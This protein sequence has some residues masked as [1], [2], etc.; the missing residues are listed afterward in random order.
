MP[1]CSTVHTGTE[2]AERPHASC[3]QGSR[4]GVP[5]AE[6]WRCRAGHGV[7]KERLLCPKNVRMLQTP[8]PATPEAMQSNVFLPH[9]PAHP[10]PPNP[11]HMQRCVDR[12]RVLGA[13]DRE[14]D[15]V[16][17]V[18]EGAHARGLP[19]QPRS[20]RRSDD[21]LNGRPLVALRQVA[22]GGAICLFLSVASFL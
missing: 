10:T 22:G 14:A 1:P 8:L 12:P 5:A 19:A 18:A 4:H 7:P 17:V 16:H 20:V 6:Q 11:T 9:H 2:T 3:S 13:R 21:G 15:L